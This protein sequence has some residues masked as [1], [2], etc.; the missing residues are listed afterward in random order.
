MSKPIAFLLILLSAGLVFVQ[1]CSGAAFGFGF[2]RSLLTA[3]TQHTATLLPDGRVLVAGGAGTNNPGINILATAELY[4]PASATWT[5]TGSLRMGRRQHTATLLANGKVLVAGGIGV[6]EDDLTS[7]VLY[8]PATG[9]WTTTGSLSG[10]RSQHTATLLPNGKVLVAGGIH[11]GSGYGGGST[12]WTAE[13]YDPASGTW[14]S[15]DRLATGRFLH[16]AELLPNGKVLVAGG[17]E[18]GINLNTLASAELF[19]PASGT[20]TA[21]GSLATGRFS[22]TATLLPDGRLLVA[23]GEHF[24][25]SGQN[26]L[27]SA[28]LY[29]PASGTWTTTG[30]MANARITHRASLLA[31]GKVL[32][33]GGYKQGGILLNS[34]ELYNPATGTWTATGPLGVARPF[35]TATLLSN[36]KVLVA[37]GGWLGYGTTYYDYA[38]LYEPIPTLLNISTR[39]RVETGDNAMIGGFIITGTEPKTVIVRGIGPSLGLPG[40]VAD[41]TI[42]VHGPSGELLGANDNWGDALTRQQIIDS[43]LAP[44][45]D[46]ESALWG[47]INP[48]AYTVIVRNKNGAPGTGLFDAYDLDYAADSKLANVSTRG[49]VQT[50]DNILIGGFIVGGGTEGSMARVL[51]RAVG[52][53]VPVTGR[54]ADSTLELRD[55]SGTLLASNDNWK[56]HPDGSSQQAEIE[57][58]GLQPANDLESALL[59]TFPAGNYTAIVRGVNNTTGT[60][61]VEVYNLP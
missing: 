9:I 44:A 38:E 5:S 23:G 4:D 14:T 32:V 1:P 30:S 26:I 39:V 11:Y 24:F 2:T 40:A 3:R 57:A 6:D 27:A 33:V 20:W 59:Q 19:D 52:P 48:G 53:S 17:L 41:P 34:A 35:F 49:L 60:G 47:V 28:E 36:G 55:A 15:T 7:A 8:D 22:H 37:G 21:T 29:D 12:L 18:E 46:L 50:E 43:G 61:L 10:A 54:L 56:T 58:T 42:E 16:T 31:N 25:Q 45:N 13:L 51:V